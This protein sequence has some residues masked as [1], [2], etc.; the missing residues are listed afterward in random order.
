M[1]GDGVSFGD[2]GMGGA[3]GKSSGSSRGRRAGGKPTIDQD[4]MDTWYPD[5]R[6]CDCCKVRRLSF[7]LIHRFVG[8]PVGRCAEWGNVKDDVLSA[9]T[10][11]FA[12]RSWE[13][14]DIVL[15]QSCAG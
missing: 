8:R 13:A 1:D 15:H 2:F 9:E 6:E 14:T 10:S 7:C 3:G 4:L 12:S 5:C 11:P